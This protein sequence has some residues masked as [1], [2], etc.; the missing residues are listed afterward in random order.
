MIET[1]LGVLRCA[2]IAEARHT[3]GAERLDV[4]VIGTNDLAKE[5]R[6]RLVKGR[7]P[8]LAILSTIVLAARAYGLDVIDGVSNDLE[9]SVGFETECRQGLDLGMDGKTLIHPKQIAAA[10][11]VFT[12]TPDEVASARQVLA[13]FAL[14]EN[15]GKGVIALGGRM[16][17]RLHAE[18]AARTVAIAEAVTADV[19]A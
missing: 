4:L 7:Q 17:E 6:S 13:A 8:M 2:E 9:D 15:S 11:T 1:P 18:M 14:P 5:T 10:N 3:A 19:A 16:V 12:P